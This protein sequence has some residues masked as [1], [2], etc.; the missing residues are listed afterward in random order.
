MHNFIVFLQA[1]RGDLNGKHVESPGELLSPS[2]NG[3]ENGQGGGE[4]VEMV[5]YRAPSMEAS[6]KVEE[7][8]TT[9]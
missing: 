5:R 4:A 7:E 2:M 8:E 9:H 3:Q 6:V 1:K